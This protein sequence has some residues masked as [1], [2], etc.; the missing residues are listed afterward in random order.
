MFIQEYSP[1]IFR[2]S[3]IK[4]YYYYYYYYYYWHEGAAEIGTILGEELD[5]SLITLYLGKIPKTVLD[6]D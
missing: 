3:P 1:N 4:G 5:F 2:F 6:S